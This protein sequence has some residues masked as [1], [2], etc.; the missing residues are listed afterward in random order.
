MSLASIKTTLASAVALVALLSTSVTLADTGM[1]RIK[2]R[3]R[4]E[5]P[6]VKQLGIENYE[7]RPSDVL[8]DVRTEDEFAVSHLF[9]ATR[10]NRVD[11]ALALLDGKPKDTRVVT[12][13]AVGWRS[14]H[15]AREL[16][17]HGYSNVVNLEGSIFAWANTDRPLYRGDKP[18]H[19]VHPY[20]WRWGRLL[21]ADVATKTPR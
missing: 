1:T 15:L 7:A 12:Y 18:V 3:V 11:T 8:I 13:C 16:E 21:K 20:N 6:E 5:F 19:G 2:E 14:S 4:A 10:A 17:K 9:G